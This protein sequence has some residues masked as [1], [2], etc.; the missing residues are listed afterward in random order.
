MIQLSYFELMAEMTPINTL[1]RVY[2]YSSTNLVRK[3]GTVLILQMTGLVFKSH[4]QSFFLTMSE[5]THLVF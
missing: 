2:T 5:K 4:S 3:Y 1:Y